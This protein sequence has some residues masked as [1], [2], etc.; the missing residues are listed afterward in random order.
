MLN[1]AWR[2]GF[3]RAQKSLR[4]C[5]VALTLGQGG[6]FCT[7]LLVYACLAGLE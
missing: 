6:L 1:R 3:E 5:P 2:E 7:F 4:C